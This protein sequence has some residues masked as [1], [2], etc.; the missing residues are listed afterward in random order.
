MSFLQQISGYSKRRGGSMSDYVPCPSCKSMGYTD[1]RTF[2]GVGYLC[3]RC[4]MPHV[5]FDIIIPQESS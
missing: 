2:N 3:V 4:A 5:D 1:E